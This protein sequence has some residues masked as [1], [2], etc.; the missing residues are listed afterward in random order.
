MGKENREP[1][2]AK[3]DLKKLRE[4]RK[5]KIAAATARMK[6][7]RKAVQALKAELRQGSKT[8]PELARA[9]NQPTSQVLY[10]LATLKKYAEVVEGEAAGSYFQYR[11]AEEKAAGE[12]GATPENPAAEA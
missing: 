2:S 11:L 12:E 6:E 4:A 8:V 3:D 1:S 5:D 9:T 7:Q 10:Y